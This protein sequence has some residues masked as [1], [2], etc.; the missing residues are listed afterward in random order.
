MMIRKSKEH[1]P[2]TRY[3]YIYENHLVKQSNQLLG[4]DTKYAY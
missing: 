1:E 4:M 2:V 3:K